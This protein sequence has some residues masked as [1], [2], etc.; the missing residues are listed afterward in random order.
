MLLQND[1]LKNKVAQSHAG[2]KPCKW[3]EIYENMDE[4]KA[5]LLKINLK[6]YHYKLPRGTEYIKTFQWVLNNNH[7]LSD[8]QVTQLQRLASE[9]AYSLYVLG[10]K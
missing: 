1:E 7:T 2:L 10:N 5:D 6:D 9:I 4:L 3:N 8:K